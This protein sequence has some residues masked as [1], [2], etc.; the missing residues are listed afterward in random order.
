MSN[1]F[2]KKSLKRVYFFVRYLVELGSI[3]R[4]IR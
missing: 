1:F 3:F 2:L 4:R